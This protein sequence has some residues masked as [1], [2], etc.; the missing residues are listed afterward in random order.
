MITVLT[1]AVFLCYAN[2]LLS[3]VNGF[4]KDGTLEQVT[5][6]QNSV[7]KNEHHSTLMAVKLKTSTIILDIHKR[8]GVQSTLLKCAGQLAYRNKHLLALFAGRRADCQQARVMCS[9]LDVKYQQ[10]YGVSISAPKLS[11]QLADIAQQR[12]MEAFG[13]RQLAYNALILNTDHASHHNTF[14]DMYKVDVS[15][16]FFKC[17]FACVGAQS[18][19]ISTWLNT[20]GRNLSTA[21]ENSTEPIAD[22]LFNISAHCLV[23]NYLVEDLQSGNLS[24]A[25]TMLCTIPGKGRTVLG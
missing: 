20:V 13:N 14:G 16:N 5:Y 8:N 21:L 7:T 6:A 4:L 23:D 19:Q 25:V 3:R 1:F 11:L 12:S 15:G 2:L 22:S 17:N 24:V 9:E 18:Q 10:T